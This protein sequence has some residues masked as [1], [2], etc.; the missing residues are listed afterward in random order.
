[1]KA[2]ITLQELAT[3]LNGKYWEKGDLK[4]VYLEEGYNT[5]KMSTK[6]Y[7]YER[8]DGTFG[9]SCRIE[10]PSQNDNW[11]TSQ[12]DMIIEGVEKAIEEI[13][14]P[15][16]ENE[17]VEVKEKNIQ[18]EL[19]KGLAEI[20]SLNSENIGDY[21]KKL[22]FHISSTNH[23]LLWNINF[24]LFQLK[25]NQRFLNEKDDYAPMIYS[26]SFERVF[27]KRER[28]SN[29][30]FSEKL[31]VVKVGE[32]KVEFEDVLDF[33]FLRKQGTNGPNKKNV[34]VVKE[35][36][37]HIT[38]KLNAVLEEEKAKRKIELENRIAQYTTELA[39]S[40]EKFKAS[41]L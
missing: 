41:K 4:R 24:N 28:S 17:V 39:D 36:P 18:E 19:S 30:P 26:N 21:L 10:C 25:T 40:I 33:V 15:V 38:D 20:K 8:K 7:V 32:T 14:N 35:I 12:E 3:K 34:Y 6:T 22:N 5:K 29:E 13:L 9:V 11:I 16:D 37:E 2:T 27:F 23:P 1:M 31:G